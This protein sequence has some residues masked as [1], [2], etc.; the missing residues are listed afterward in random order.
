M[1]LKIA[2]FH[3]RFDE[4]GGAELFIVK[5]TAELRKMGH[6]VDVYGVRVNPIFKEVKQLSKFASS[7]IFRNLVIDFMDQSSRVCFSEDFK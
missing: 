1:P 3:P 5:M 2:V 4:V 7:R 6:K